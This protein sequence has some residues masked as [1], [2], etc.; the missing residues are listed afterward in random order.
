MTLNSGE[1]L[2]LRQGM[3]VGPVLCAR[4]RFCLKNFFFAAR[5]RYNVPESVVCQDAQALTAVRGWIRL[6]GTKVQLLYICLDWYREVP[7]HLNSMLYSDV[8]A[9]TAVH[10]WLVRAEPLALPLYTSSI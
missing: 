3:A 1:E 9:L 10:E 7:D 6:V 2:R 4:T 8:Q 5:A